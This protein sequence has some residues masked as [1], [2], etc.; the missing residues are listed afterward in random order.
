MYAHLIFIFGVTLLGACNAS[1]GEK[2]IEPVWVNL[3]NNE[4]VVPVSPDEPESVT[5]GFTTVIPEQNDTV[6]VKQDSKVGVDLKSE[7]L[8][9]SY[10]PEYCRCVLRQH[11]ASQYAVVVDRKKRAVN[12]PACLQGHVMCCRPV[13]PGC[14]VVDAFPYFPPFPSYGEANFAEYPWTAL[15]MDTSNQLYGI[16]ITIAWRTVITS[17]RN[18]EQF[19]GRRFKVRL[20]EWDL[21]SSNEPFLPQEY[22]V[23]EVRVH[24]QFN[25]RTF[26]ND[27]A[28]L[29]LNASVNLDA[30]PHIRSACLART[31][32]TSK[33][34]SSKCITAGWGNRP[35]TR[36]AS[37]KNL[38]K[39]VDLQVFDAG[40]CQQAIRRAINNPDYY[41]DHTSF[42]CAGGQAGKGLCKGDEGG[43]L[44]CQDTPTSR[45][46][47]V[48][49]SSWGNTCGEAGFP[50]VFTNMANYY[51]WIKSVDPNIGQ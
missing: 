15:V 19:L 42:I 32:D 31:G 34:I 20:G 51:D 22:T 30:F 14:G 26:Q 7:D 21:S 16:G 2:I 47:V 44:I 33:Y 13:G 11:C 36:I 41:W 29:R 17:A 28:I 40:V 49:M 39:E 38:L 1:G 24:P 43:A 35:S 48:G 9:T 5:E 23:T 10:L 50:G 12:T 8:S 37:G 4:T 25:P 3:R 6:Y 46:T 18:V 45:F 27:I